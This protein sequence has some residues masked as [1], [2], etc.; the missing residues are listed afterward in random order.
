MNLTRLPC[1]G[2]INDFNIFYRIEMLLFLY[3]SK[4]AQ[5]LLTQEVA[6]YIYK[7]PIDPKFLYPSKSAPFCPLSH[8]LATAVIKERFLCPYSY[9]I[10]DREELSPYWVRWWNL[11][12]AGMGVQLCM[13]ERRVSFLSVHHS[14][15]VSIPSTSH[16]FT[17]TTCPVPFSDALWLSYMLRC[18]KEVFNVSMFW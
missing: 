17:T 15:T 16:P 13:Y 6:L 18:M 7:S 5:P 3:C 1:S 10:R 4:L 14:Q 8:Q 11:A 12:A 2:L 9:C